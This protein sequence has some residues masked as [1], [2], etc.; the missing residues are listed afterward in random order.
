[1]V[2]DALAGR[3]TF[4]EQLRAQQAQVEAERARYGLSELRF[5]HGVSNSLELLDAER[6]LFTFEVALVQARLSQLQNRVSLYRALAGG[7]DV[8]SPA[9]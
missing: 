9:S 8:A 6:S 2:A 7:L 4:D 5:R 1:D 3:A